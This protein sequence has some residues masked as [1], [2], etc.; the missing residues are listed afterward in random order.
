V[1]I[2]RQVKRA[3]HMPPH[4]LARKVVA[5]TTRFWTAKQLLLH[6][7]YR[8]SYA[9]S[10]P[11][12]LLTLRFTDM[13]L[14]PLLQRK[15]CIRAIAD[16]VCSHQFDLLGS[17]KTTVRY[18]ATYPGLEGH[19]FPPALPEYAGGEELPGDGVTQANLQESTRCWQLIDFPY[20]P[21]DWHVD[22]KSGYRWTSTAR[23]CDIR[24]GQVIGADVKV[25]W[26][27]ARMQHGPLLALAYGLSSDFVARARYLREFR[28]Q[29]LDF[30]ATNPP[31]FGVNW[32]S[33]MDV[34][35]RVINWL[36][37]YDLFVAQGATFDDLFVSVL[38][39][40]VYEHGCHIVRH[41]EWDPEVR[42]NHYLSDIV[43]LL[44]VAAY[45][46]ASTETDAW[47]ALAAQEY[48]QEVALQFHS[49]GANF[50]ASTCYHRLSSELFV[51]GAALLAGIS[52]DR[53]AR[54]QG[55]NRRAVRRAAVRLKRPVEWHRV[56]TLCS[57]LSA[58]LWKRLER[59]AEF[60][61]DVTMP[62][63]QVAQI[64]DN[65]SGRIL[66]FA[67]VMI[68]GENDEYVE[69]HLDHRQ[70]VASINGIFDRSDFRQFSHVYEFESQV[71]RWLTHGGMVPSDSTW[72]ARSYEKT[73][74]G[75]N[76]MDLQKET[77]PLQQT[78]QFETQDAE[79]LTDR[80]MTF[81]YP[82]FGLY[83]FRSHRLHVTI[84]CGTVGQNGFGGHAHNDQL[85]IT[86]W[87]NGVGRVLDPGSYIY[88]P[89][90]TRRNAYRSVHAHF[91]PRMN[92]AE[93][94]PFPS[95]PFQLYETPGRACLSFKAFEFVGV[96]MGFGEPVM[97][98]VRVVSD[99]VLV[100]DYCASPLVPIEIA[101]PF[102]PGYG[103]LTG[104]SKDEGRG[105]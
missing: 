85:S 55:A 83:G 27:L 67:P 92:S 17:G 80:L 103:L 99:R 8:S 18:G 16:S 26:E 24:Y 86:V 42:G 72:Q 21:I 14:T 73:A 61:M 32:S 5:R 45:L 11:T 84:R 69:D 101:V 29:V 6:D 94:A 76:E 36:V 71:I 50:E 88:T 62:D 79:A 28:N 82:D 97:R 23:S 53:R 12:G 105:A 30:I 77:L 75:A 13:S 63:G 25:P 1:T 46:P 104:T 40:S 47:L 51:Y 66:K 52:S 102:S 89:L 37:A 91:A 4:I 49:D 10:S 95:A 54:L 74:C 93:P 19:K 58:D 98:H 22:F 2:L 81:S 68:P 70:C 7:R 3:I 100:E 78:A 64:G 48:T 59:A 31:R 87:L 65:D 57:P 20:D 90:L 43:G 38:L 56:G 39:R 44:F 34:A 41:L 96:H 33:T 15:D 35:I 60:V 9:K